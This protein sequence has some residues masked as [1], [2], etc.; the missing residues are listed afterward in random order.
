MG[1]YYD[2]SSGITIPKANEKILE[3]FDED[4]YE[5]LGDFLDNLKLS[6]ST[7]GNLYDGQEEY[8]ISFTQGVFPIETL[9]ERLQVWID[10]VNSI[11]QTSYTVK[12]CKEFSEAL[13][14]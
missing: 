12:D 6:Y 4:K 9:Q 11:L 13:V 10:K 8:R 1:I 5:T 7:V 2:A 3:I 14:H